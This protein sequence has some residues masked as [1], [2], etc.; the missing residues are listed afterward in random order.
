MMQ[1]H[2]HHWQE[3]KIHTAYGDCS[4]IGDLSV[5]EDLKVVISPE[6]AELVDSTW[7]L[8]INKLSDDDKTPAG[9]FSRI[10]YERFC[11][12][13]PPASKEVRPCIVCRG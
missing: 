11:E 9:D 13:G 2:A 4:D 5:A 6:E 8:A 10:V 1:M 3:P 7:R 12:I